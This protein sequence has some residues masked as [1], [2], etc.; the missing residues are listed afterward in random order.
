MINVTQN[1]IINAINYAN[2][3]QSPSIEITTQNNNNTFT[4][5]IKD[6][7]IGI[8][9]KHQSK[10]FEMFNRLKEKKEVNGTGIGLATCLKIVQMHNGSITVD[11]I[12]NKGS[13]F[14][15]KLPVKINVSV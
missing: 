5:I 10:I 7:G 13:E 2:P 1:I 9:Q 4:L 6:N 15:I 14:I 12:P 3:N 8:D 11:Y